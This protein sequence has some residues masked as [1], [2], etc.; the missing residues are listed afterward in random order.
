MKIY[1]KS[2]SKIILIMIFI[3]S[4]NKKIDNKKM[5]IANTKSITSNDL[6]TT[7]DISTKV[8]QIDQ[9]EYSYNEDGKRELW[10]EKSIVFNDIGNTS[11]ISEKWIVNDFG[12]FVTTFT[13]DNQNRILKSETN[14]N[15]SKHSYTEYNY[16]QDSIFITEIHSDTLYEKR[17]KVVDKKGNVV[18]EQKFDAAGDFMNKTEF[19]YDKNNRKISGKNYYQVIN[20]NYPTCCN[21]YIDTLTFKYDKNNFLLSESNN[22]PILFQYSLLDSNNNWTIKKIFT[23][24]MKNIPSTAI[25]R[26]IIYKN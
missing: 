19:V 6:K 2:F 9:K 12:T 4:C 7:Y 20:K 8:T 18:F 25:E 21:V 24:S 10:F 13:Y 11:S 5:M 3:V 17:T 22:N 16:K 15:N 23:D 14:Q 1:S 26:K